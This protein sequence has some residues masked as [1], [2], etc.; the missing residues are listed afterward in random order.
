MRIKTDV[1]HGGIYCGSFFVAGYVLPLIE[2]LVL[3][4]DLDMCVPLISILYWQS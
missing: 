4:G 2:M 3:C 1:L